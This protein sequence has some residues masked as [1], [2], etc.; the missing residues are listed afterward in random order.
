MTLSVSIP[1]VI[2]CVY[3]LSALRGGTPR[4]YTRNDEPA[5]RALI[6][7][8]LANLTLAWLPVINSMTRSEDIVEIDIKSDN[9]CLLG[10]IESYL[11]DSAL[12]AASGAASPS[13]PPCPQYDGICHA[14]I[15]PH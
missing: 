10:V 11:I 13:T 3:A 7:P 5:L 9:P 6:D 12:A 14:T 1:R 2:E 8:M 15:Q 4:L